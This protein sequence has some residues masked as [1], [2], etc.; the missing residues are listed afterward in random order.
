MR[1]T[2]SHL[3]IEVNA[4]AETGPIRASLRCRWQWIHCQELAPDRSLQAMCKALR[5]GP[6]SCH[7]IPNE[8]L[9]GYAIERL[10]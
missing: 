3:S 8:L 6:R 10:V 1:G 7:H 5:R 2:L 9:G 4:V